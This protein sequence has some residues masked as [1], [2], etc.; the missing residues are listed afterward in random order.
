MRAIEGEAVASGSATWTGLMERAGAAAVEALYRHAPDLTA[1]GRTALVLCGPGNNGG[2]G[3]VIARHL[4]QR[5]WEVTAAQ[6]G[7]PGGLPDAAR[8]NRERLVPLG[9]LRAFDDLTE[10]EIRAGLTVDALFGT[11]FSRPLPEDPRHGH[12]MKRARFVLAVDVPTGLEADTG[13]VLAP[14][15]AA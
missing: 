13:R 11:G 1:P 5:G 3:Y 15:S 6:W 8:A 2:D 12:I 7:D 9:R 10:A 14:A 4:A